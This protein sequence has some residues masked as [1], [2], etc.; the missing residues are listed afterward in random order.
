MSGFRDLFAALLTRVQDV[1]PWGPLILAGAYVPA[2]VLFVPGSLLTLGAGFLFGPIVGTLVVSAGSTVGAGA[3]FLIGR[4]V[5][6]TSVARHV[7][8]R[9]RLAALVHAV[10][11]HPFKIV[12]LTR[13][14]PLF[15]FTVLNY[16]FGL[17]SVPFRTYVL[18]SWIGM[19]PGTIT[20]VLLGATA[21]SMASALS[22]TRSRSGSD[23]AL[24]AIGLAATI[25]ATVIITRS[26]RRALEDALKV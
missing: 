2:A 14:S 5:A 1:G 13:L 11:A 15:P 21:N 7:D 18:A 26:A 20:Y 22:G 4:R 17:T 10:A 8:K 12:F 16:A 25:I 3:A 23:L 19:L 9:P 24:A 6:R